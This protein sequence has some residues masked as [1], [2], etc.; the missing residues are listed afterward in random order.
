[1][2]FPAVEYEEIY[3]KVG[4]IVSFYFGADISEGEVIE[5]FPLMNHCRVRLSD[6]SM[7]LVDGEDLL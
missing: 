6:G 5:I 3:L 7:L 2:E 4:D 1:M